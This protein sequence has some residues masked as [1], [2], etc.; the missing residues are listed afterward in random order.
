[1]YGAGVEQAALQ[2]AM[3]A[4]QARSAQAVTPSAGVIPSGASPEPSAPPQ[5]VMQAA[6]QETPAERYQRAIMAAQQMKGEPGLFTMPTG[7]PNEP[8]THGLPVGPGAGPEVL[9]TLVGSPVG[10]VMRNLT[11]MTGDP[12]FA[13]LARKAQA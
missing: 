12:L 13:E 4:P 3:P 1:M 7:R 5:P 10:E 9:N 2:A 11:R 6:P 8:V